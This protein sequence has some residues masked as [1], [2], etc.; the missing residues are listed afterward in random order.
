MITLGL[1]RGA[2]IWRVSVSERVTGDLPSH[3]NDA[4][5]TE[6]ERTRCR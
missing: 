2:T 5:L 1:G 4:R 3:L 6:A